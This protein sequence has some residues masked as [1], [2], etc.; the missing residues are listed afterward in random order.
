M[1]ITRTRGYNAKG[2]GHYKDKNYNGEYRGW[3]HD[4]GGRG[5]QCEGAM[6]DFARKEQTKGRKSQ[7][8][9]KY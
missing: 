8:V 9:K 7:E 3:T 2:K 1:N 5:V 4:M 6:N